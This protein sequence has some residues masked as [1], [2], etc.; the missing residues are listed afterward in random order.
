MVCGIY[1]DERG[2]NSKP[3]D[4]ELG[5]FFGEREKFSLQELCFVLYYV[6]R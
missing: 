6:S 2:L 3:R 4:D 5:Y 1:L